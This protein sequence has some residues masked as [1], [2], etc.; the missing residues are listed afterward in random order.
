MKI[1]LLGKDG[2]VGSELKRSLL[3]LGRLCAL[4]RGDLC[5]RNTSNLLDKLHRHKPDIIVNAAAYTAVDKAESD[6]EMAHLINEEVVGLLAEYAY[7]TKALLLHYSTDYVFDGLKKEAYT[8]SDH[9]NPQNVY[10]ISKRAGELAILRSQCKH[11]I[12]RTSWVFSA[13]G[14]NFVKTILGLARDRTSLRVVDDQFGAPTSAELIADVTALALS[15]YCNDRL[16]EGIY[17]LTATGTTSWYGLACYALDKAYAQGMD[18]SLEVKNIEPIST[19]EYPLPAK[20]PRNSK[21]D[22]S[23]LSSALNLHLPQWEVYVDRMV[24]QLSKM[25]YVR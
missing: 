23:A 7:S 10:G 25:E 16:E 12:L 3:P 1:L 4:G 6:I 17:H 2:Q 21:L 19:E 8:E 14:A 9:T 24:E 5:L 20:R 18:L 11:V 15:G 13:K 22:V